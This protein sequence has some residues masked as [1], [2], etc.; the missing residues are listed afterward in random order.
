MEKNTIQTPELDHLSPRDYD[1]IYEPA[2]DSFL[3]LDALELELSRLR[4]AKPCL[5]LEVGSGS[6]V[7]LTGLATALGPACLYLATDINP[8]ACRTTI[9]TASRNGCE[10]Q[11]VN[12][13][14]VAGLEERLLGG[15]DVLLF[16]PPYV[17]TPSEEVARGSL[18][19]T[20]AGGNKGREVLDRLLPSVPRLLSD[21]GRFYLLMEQNNNPAEV[22]LLLAELGLVKSKK[23]LDRRTGPEKLS[24]WAY[25]KL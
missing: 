1:G 14:L 4:A 23:I 22:S 17:V 25:S 6:G 2:E 7:V 15:V 8:A 13:D 11:A 10:V 3:L 18:E 21:T 19:H 24:V 20:W 5:C 9:R 16:N 12:T